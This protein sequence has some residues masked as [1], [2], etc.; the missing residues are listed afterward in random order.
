MCSPASCQQGHQ[1]PLSTYVRPNLSSAVSAAIM[2]PFHHSVPCDQLQGQSPLLAPRGNWAAR[3]PSP[4]LMGCSLV[5]Q[6]LTRR[7]DLGYRLCV[8]G[9]VQL[10][11]EKPWA[12]HKLWREHPSESRVGPQCLVSQVCTSGH[13]GGI[14]WQH[15]WVSCLGAGDWS[16]LCERRAH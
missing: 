15:L 2:G 9:Q 16:A 5:L 8:R 10:S 14:G 13:P 11:C 12:S 1:V 7:W 4:K 3:N 6:K